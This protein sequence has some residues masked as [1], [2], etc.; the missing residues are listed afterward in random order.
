MTFAGASLRPPLAFNPR[1]RRLSTPSDAFE[2]HPDVASYGT[3][4]SILTG[5]SGNPLCVVARQLDVP[6]HDI[7]GTCPL[8]AEGGGARADA[9]TD[10]K[11]EREYNEALAE[12]TR[13]RLAFG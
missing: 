1:P 2:L 3:T 4:L 9:A 12:C 10:E 8:Y 7:R 13:K 5:S 11:I 6:F